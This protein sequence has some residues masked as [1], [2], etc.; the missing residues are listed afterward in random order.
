MQ[1]YTPFKYLT[2]RV[3]WEST[4]VCSGYSAQWGK[5]K[6]KNAISCTACRKTFCANDYAKWQS[7]TDGKREWPTEREWE[8]QE[9]EKEIEME[10]EREEGAGKTDAYCWKCCWLLWLFKKLNNCQLAKLPL[11]LLLPLSLSLSPTLSFSLVVLLHIFGTFLWAVC[12]V[13]AGSSCRPF[14]M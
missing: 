8:E 6:K 14:A 7:S 12:G 1:C 9:Q 5:L 3:Q 11:S 13:I 10:I 4:S 2:V